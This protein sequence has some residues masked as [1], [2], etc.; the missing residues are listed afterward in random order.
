MRLD[1]IT[2]ADILATGDTRPD[3]AFP[4]YVPDPRELERAK[5]LDFARADEDRL[6]AGEIDRDEAEIV[7]TTQLVSVS[8]GTLERHQDAASVVQAYLRELAAEQRRREEAAEKGESYEPRKIPEPPEYREKTLRI[9]VARLIAEGVETWS[10][11]PKA[12][13]PVPSADLKRGDPVPVPFDHLPKDPSDFTEKGNRVVLDLVDALPAAYAVRL[14]MAIGWI[15]N[16]DVRRF[17]PEPKEVEEDKAKP[18]SQRDDLQDPPEAGT[19]QGES[20]AAP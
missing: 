16:L 2:L 12:V 6:L 17:F 8:S 13:V 14:T 1:L 19:P 11:A 9:L 7:R 3:E 15:S 4:W 20:S 18:P 5:L 10:P